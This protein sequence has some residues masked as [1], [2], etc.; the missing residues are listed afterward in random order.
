METGDSFEVIK[1]IPAASL[2]YDV[3]GTCYT[4]VK[5]PEDPTQATATFS[6]TMKFIV[7]DCDPTTGE[8]DDDGY[9][10]EYVVCFICC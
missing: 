2:P 10:D 9:E 5:I 8:A 3:P 1:Y 4:L 7:K 6:C